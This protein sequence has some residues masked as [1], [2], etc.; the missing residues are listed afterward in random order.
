M[1]GLVGIT[2][3]A[4]FVT[5]MGALAIGAAAGAICLWAVT[6]KSKLGYDDTLDVFGIHGIGGLVGALLTGV[7][8][9]EP[10]AGS[11]GKQVVAQAIGAVAAAAYAMVVS[12]IL[13]KIIDAT[14]GLRVTPE[15]EELGLDTTQH[16][17]T[18]YNL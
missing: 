7:L 13:L 14:I 17:E 18:G 1:A 11:M 15:E 2:P 16:G 12:W 5:V 4:G 6:M 9:V 10:F 3:A 8:A